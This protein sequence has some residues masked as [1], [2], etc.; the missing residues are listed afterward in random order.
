MEI[1][2]RRNRLIHLFSVVAIYA[3]IFA[4]IHYRQGVVDPVYRSARRL[5]SIDAGRRLEALLEL[6]QIGPNATS[7]IQAILETVN[8]IDPRVRVESIRTLGNMI[9]APMNKDQVEQARASF[10]AALHD[11]I[12]AVRHSAALALATIDPGSEATIVPLIEAAGDD[13]PMVRGE[14]IT[15]LAWFGE[16]GHEESFHTLL[17]CLKDRDPSMRTRAV[18]LLS[19]S[20]LPPKYTSTVATAL[21][22]TLEDESAHIRADAVIAVAKLAHRT[23]LGIRGLI[24]AM[25]DPSPY[26]RTMAI[27]FT[28]RN[29]DPASY[30]VSLIQATADPDPGVRE[31]ACSNLSYPD[32]VNREETVRA[33][34]LRL[35]DKSARVRETASEKL[36]WIGADRRPPKTAETPIP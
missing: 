2:R 18:R 30:F 22:S 9:S 21:V 36:K 12:P 15:H 8:D 31:V 5:R 13:D 11:P 4:Y 17:G 3:S 14:A 16:R 7:A 32:E 19:S 35:T 26:V 33:L 1:L 20:S 25:S 29:D 10:K 34:R 28:P 27:S 6:R 24:R 23:P